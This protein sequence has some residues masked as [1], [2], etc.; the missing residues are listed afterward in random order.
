VGVRPR[1]D[2][3]AVV[4]SVGGTQAPPEFDPPDTKELTNEPAAAPIVPSRPAVT[5]KY[6]PPDWLNPPRTE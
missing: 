6:E 1:M 5:M 2:D 4:T 3:I